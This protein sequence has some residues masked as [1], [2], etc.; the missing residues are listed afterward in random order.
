[1]PLVDRLVAAT[2]GRQLVTGRPGVGWLTVE[3]IPA[4]IYTQITGSIS[5]ELYYLVAFVTLLGAGPTQLAYLPMMFFAANIAQAWL[6]LRRPPSDPRRACVI[7]TAIGR[8]LWLGIVLWPLLGWWL[9]WGS[10][11]ILAGVFV[12]IFL[13]QLMHAAGVAAFITWTQAI[14]PR[15]RRGIFFA[16]RSISSFVVVAVLLYLVGLALP[17]S[18][19]PVHAFSGDQLPWLGVL[20]GSA[21]VIGILGVWGLAKGPAVP[22]AGEAR[23]FAPLWPQMRANAPFLRFTGWSLLIILAVAASAVY[24]PLI[25]QSAGVDASHY[26]K[27]Q[28]LIFY[29]AMLGGI[30][31]AGWALPRIHGRRLLLS[32]HLLLILGEV[33]M[34]GLTRERSPWLTP[35]VLALLGV[36][37]GAWGI[38]WISR[39]QELIPPGDPRFFGVLITLGGAIGLLGSFATLTLMPQL[40]AAIAADPTLPAVG[41]LMVGVGIVFRV[42]ATPLLAWGDQGR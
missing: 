33:A 36:A 17:P 37:K 6:V 29:P 9:D 22:V 18:A 11:A 2:G 34:L 35:T 16:W 32:A 19:D 25:F 20:L 31:I 8:S 27:S 21:T 40:Q 42:L 23:P 39:I 26:A 28:A 1:M 10:T 15:E 12:S 13:G 5:M 4:T 7:D 41:V 3:V 30:L 14:I 38:A 24:Q